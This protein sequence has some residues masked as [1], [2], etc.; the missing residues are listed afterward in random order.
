M[1]PFIRLHPNDNVL[2][3][4]QPLV[5]GSE[6]AA[7]PAHARPGAGRPQDR[8]ARHRS[9][10]AGAP[11]RPVIGFAT[12]DIA[13]ASTCT[14]TTSS[15]STSSATR[16]RRGRAADRTTCRGAARPSWASCGADGRVATRNFIGILTSV[17]CSATVVAPR[18]PTTSDATRPAALADYPNVDGV[19]ALA[20][21][22]RLR[23]GSAGEPLRRAAPHDRRLRA[24]SEPRRRR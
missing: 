23:H 18:S 9:R 5:G 3:A 15:W 11:L 16:V 2:I 1:Q 14:R 20:H 6:L 17:N 22:Q 12:R 24:P 8:G 10:R 19:V 21:D 4:R 7:R 13:P